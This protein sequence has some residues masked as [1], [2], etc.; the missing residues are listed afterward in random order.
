MKDGIRFVKAGELN[1]RVFVRGHGV[2][3]LLLHGF[4]DNLEMWSK[5]VPDLVAAGYKVIA[6]DQRGFGGTDA[7]P[8]RACYK[9]EN[10]VNDIPRLL[11]EL[12]IKGPVHVLG[13]DWGAITGWCFALFYPDMV[14]SL[15]AVSVGHPQSYGKAGLYQKLIKGFYVLW[16]QA[17]GMAEYYLLHGGF[18]RWMPSHPKGEEVIKEMSRPGRLTASINLYRAN[19]LDVLLKP[20]PRC[21]VPVLGIWSDGDDY[22]TEEQMKNSEKYM[23]ADWQYLRIKGAGHW[24]PLE[25]PAVLT[26]ESVS[27]FSRWGND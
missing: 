13:H 5:M 3:L 14:K 21:R 16:F 11:N 9:I 26:N 17:S 8:G 23:E 12:E 25:N 6:F 19:L 22:L 18:K 15:L 7:P 2:P 10:L 1:F 4:P 24:I 20:W 27:W